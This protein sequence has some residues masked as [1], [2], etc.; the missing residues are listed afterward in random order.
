[1]RV[2]PPH[3]R[4]QLAALQLRS[5][6]TDDS[7]GGRSAARSHPNRSADAAR[8]LCRCL[9]VPPAPPDRRPQL[10]HA[11][12]CALCN[13]AP[14]QLRSDDSYCGS[15]AVQRRGQAE[16]QEKLRGSKVAAEEQVRPHHRVLPCIALIIA[17]MCWMTQG[18]G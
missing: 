8:L 6:T 13:S 14:L 18:P 12:S 5:T 17:L 10:L 3:L 16:E 2:P 9:R 1:M 11:Y 7:P 4:P 15:M